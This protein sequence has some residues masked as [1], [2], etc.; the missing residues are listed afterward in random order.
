MAPQ[1]AEKSVKVVFKKDQPVFLKVDADRV[2]QILLNLLLNGLDAMAAAGEIRISL[3]A[4]G[5]TVKISVADQGSGIA[6]VVAP[7]IFD[8]YFTTKTEGTGM[9]LA[10]CRKIARLHGG[11]LHF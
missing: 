1:A 2:Q 11:D 6:S 10:V 5:P 9:G 3:A 8:P 4:Q 7:Y